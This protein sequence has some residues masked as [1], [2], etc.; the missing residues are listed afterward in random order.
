MT[1]PRPSTLSRRL[2]S[3]SILALA[4]VV[5]SLTLA[6]VWHEWDVHRR[7]QMANARALLD[8][9]AGMSELTEHEASARAQVAMLAEALRPSGVLLELRRPDE[10]VP[11]AMDVVAVRPLLVQ[12]VELQ[13]AYGMNP[14]EMRRVLLR[15]AL[16]H[17]AAGGLLLVLA[18]V[19]LNALMRARVRFPLGRLAHQIRFMGSG[20]GWEPRL[21]PADAEIAEV[22]DALR[23]LGPALTDQ[24]SVRLEAER[25]AV[26]TAMASELKARLRGPLRAALVNLGDLQANDLVPP[27]GKQR[28]RAAVGALERMVREID[29]TI[30]AR[31]RGVS[32][33][34]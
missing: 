34:S 25:R 18:L 23:G 12:G 5:L 16:V 11:A 21:P 7:T 10:A 27:L 31:L 1:L 2:S 24:V 19:A 29:A 6:G 26:T 9:L 22:N 8:H 15:S 3:W 30:D 14:S 33:P 4:M 20:G 28:V 32:P 13:I 17:V